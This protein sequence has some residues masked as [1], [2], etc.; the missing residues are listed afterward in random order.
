MKSS[1]PSGFTS[2]EMLEELMRAIEN[3]NSQISGK[4]LLA[5]MADRSKP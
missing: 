5:T 3:P 2:Q 4:G 1:H